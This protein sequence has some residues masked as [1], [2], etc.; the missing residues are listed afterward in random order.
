[1]QANPMA[2]LDFPLKIAVVRDGGKIFVSYREPESMTR[3]WHLDPVPKQIGIASNVLNQLANIA[4]GR[5]L[6][7]ADFA[8]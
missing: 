8:K 6:V 2:A 1:M 5:H 4:A 3:T 7:G